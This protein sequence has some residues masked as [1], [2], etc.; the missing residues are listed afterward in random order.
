MIWAI[1]LPGLKQII[2]AIFNKNSNLNSRW[3]IEKYYGPFWMRS[4]SE[5]LAW[6]CETTIRKKGRGI[7][8]LLPAYFCGQSLRYLRSLDVKF[9]FY[10][11]DIN[12][13]S[14]KKFIQSIVKENEIDIF[15]LVHYFGIINVCTQRYIKTF[16]DANN[17]LVIEDYAHFNHP[18][19]NSQFLGNYVFFS[20]RKHY[21][22][23]NG[24]ALYSL[25][26]M[27]NFIYEREKIPL[28][29]YLKRIARRYCNYLLLSNKPAGRQN[30]AEVNL[31]SFKEPS[32]FDYKMLAYYSG[33]IE[34]YQKLVYH[35][36]YLLDKL[37]SEP[38][39]AARV[40]KVRVFNAN[41]T[42]LYP[43]I[44]HHTKDVEVFI[45]IFS[46]NK[47]PAIIWPD[48]P[49]EIVNV[50]AEYDKILDQVKKT[51]FIPVHHDINGEKLVKILRYCFDDK[52]QIA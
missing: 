7:Q 21:P 9:L 51:I 41:I 43:M 24:A 23:K 17:I 6:I 15:L 20:P 52:I 26:R 16:C 33:N 5:I 2:S 38:K 12:N 14:D 22:I 31:I 27:D 25:E 4:G 19:M 8:I 18:N 48:L 10:P 49:L 34:H 3:E 50:F 28:L 29:W 30:S 40:G 13:I 47:I 42:Y 46:K 11:S 36:V 1:P 32:N 44:F 39:I 45:K 35:N 37:I